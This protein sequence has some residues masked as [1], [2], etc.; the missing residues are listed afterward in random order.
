[1]AGSNRV[2]RYVGAALVGP[3]RCLY[4]EYLGGRRRWVVER[5]RLN[6]VRMLETLETRE[7]QIRIILE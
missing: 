6:Q 4:L 7:A 5:R 2:Q 3:D 1:M